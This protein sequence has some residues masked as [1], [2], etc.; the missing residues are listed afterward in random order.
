V[1]EIV[2]DAHT[3]VSQWPLL[4]R[5]APV[6]DLPIPF[7]CAGGRSL[8]GIGILNF[9]PGRPFLWPKSQ[10]SMASPRVPMTEGTVILRLRHGIIVGIQN[11]KV[12]IYR[13]CDNDLIGDRQPRRVMTLTGR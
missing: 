3:M 4:E 1:I 10:R 5:G 9:L 13:I 11:D 8:P 6:T 7:Q 2:C 12:Y